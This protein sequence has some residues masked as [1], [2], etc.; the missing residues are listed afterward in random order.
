VENAKEKILYKK[1]KESRMQLVLK[2]L[3]EIHRRLYGSELNF[4]TEDL[5]S[6]ERAS[7]F[8]HKLEEMGLDNPNI[9]SFLKEQSYE[10]MIARL[11]L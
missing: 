3:D 6:F 10:E 8:E 7:A 11:L 1:Q 4:K 2:E 9:L 5:E